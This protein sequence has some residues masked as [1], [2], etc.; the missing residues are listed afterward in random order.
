MTIYTKMPITLCQNPRINKYLPCSAWENT[1]T[2][3]RWLPK[4]LFVNW[5]T[6]I[7]SATNCSRVWWKA[8]CY[9]HLFSS[10]CSVKRSLIWTHAAGL[11]VRRRARAQAGEAQRRPRLPAQVPLRKLPALHRGRPGPAGA[12]VPRISGG[13]LH[14]PAGL[15]GEGC[16]YLSK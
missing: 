2:T 13:D 5:S 6:Q 3:I 8:T 11:R 7:D 4:T 15:Q 1:K 9:F 14:A 16:G 12:L 10:S